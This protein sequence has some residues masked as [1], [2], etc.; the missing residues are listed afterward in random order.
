MCH[1]NIEWE[2]QIH[3]KRKLVWDLSP[4]YIMLQL[5]KLTNFQTLLIQKK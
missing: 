1:I 5:R 3:T 4:R 2:R